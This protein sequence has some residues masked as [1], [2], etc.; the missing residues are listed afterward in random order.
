MDA[1]RQ[2]SLFGAS[3]RWPRADRIGAGFGVLFVL[4]ASTEWARAADTN[5]RAD[6]RRR[7][8]D[9]TA[10]HDAAGVQA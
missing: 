9:R 4:I 2:V 5:A 1:L 6:L 7:D 10:L 3:R 8:R